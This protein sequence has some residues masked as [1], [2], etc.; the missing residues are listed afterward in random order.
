MKIWEQNLAEKIMKGKQAIKQGKKPKRS[1]F[2]AL[3][4]KLFVN[5]AWSA[6]EWQDFIDV[7]CKE[8]KPNDAVFEVLMDALKRETGK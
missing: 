8:K 2:A 1:Y 3:E 6:K 7:F 5:F 4:G